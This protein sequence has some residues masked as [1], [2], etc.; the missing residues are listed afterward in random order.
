LRRV[1]SSDWSHLKKEERKKK[2]R[3]KKK[4]GRHPLPLIQAVREKGGKGE[5]KRKGKKGSLDVGY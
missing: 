3:K 4:T 5:Q 2:K 1:R